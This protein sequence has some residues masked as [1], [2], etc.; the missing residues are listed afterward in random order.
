[1]SRGLYYVEFEHHEDQINHDKHVLVQKL[2]GWG[3]DL[4]IS[5][6]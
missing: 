2:I 1:M 5:V 4:F 6:L 3:E